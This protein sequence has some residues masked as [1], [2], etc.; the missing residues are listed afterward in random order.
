MPQQKMVNF[1]H[2][3]Q[4]IFYVLQYTQREKRDHFRGT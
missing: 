4:I 2:Q 3:F 1:A